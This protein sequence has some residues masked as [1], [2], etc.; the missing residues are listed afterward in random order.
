M[1]M[2]TMATEVSLKRSNRLG[3]HRL[4][5][6]LNCMVVA[7]IIAS[8]L[9]GGLVS[10][11]SG[12]EAWY[13]R[14][15][16]SIGKMMFFYAWPTDTY[17]YMEF[18]NIDWKKSGADVSVVLHGTSW[19][20]GKTWTEV[21]VEIRNGQVTNMRFGRYGG[22]LWAP[23]TVMDKAI[24][25]LNDEYKRQ[26]ALAAPQPAA[27]AAP[28]ATL[29]ILCLNNP[30]SGPIVYSL[31][32]EGFAAKALAPGE[33]WMFSHGGPADFTVSFAGMRNSSVRKTV[34][35][36]GSM[37]AS[38]PSSCSANMIYEFV[39]DDQRVGLAPRTWI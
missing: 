6:I 9:C 33:T 4:G 27:P 2:K 8:F 1:I 22:A 24:Q 26:Q 20:E 15:I 17:D 35:V 16:N 25:A 34:R 10:A 12:D 39:V 31:P 23:G 28:S 36:R 21:V 19:L 18:G 3:I 13:K 14:F 32:S 5:R 29:A 37:Q 38:K 7:L 30:T 11:Q